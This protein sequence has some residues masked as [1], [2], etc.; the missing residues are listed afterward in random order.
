VFPMPN[1]GQNWLLANKN[2]QNSNRA[3]D[4]FQR[5]SHQKRSKSTPVDGELVVSSGLAGMDGL[6]PG[7]EVATAPIQSQP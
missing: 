3:T 1:Q 2:A 7:D 4:P 6:L 5:N